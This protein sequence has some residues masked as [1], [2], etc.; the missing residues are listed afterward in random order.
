MFD[1]IELKAAAARL[2]YNN[3]RN[4]ADYNALVGFIDQVA[5][6]AKKFR[7]VPV[8]ER[9]PANGRKVLLYSDRGAV[10]RGYYDHVHRCWRTTKTV[11]ITHWRVPDGP[12][13]WEE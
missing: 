1:A 11:N 4:S 12:E 13:D 8:T 7:W 6:M 3:D 5:C 2:L 9:L 10:F